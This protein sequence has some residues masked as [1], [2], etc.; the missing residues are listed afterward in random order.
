M[1]ATAKGYADLLSLAERC[2]PIAKPAPAQARP[3]VIEADDDPHRL[4]RINLE[5]Y[6]SLEEGATIRF[7]RDEWYTWKLSRGC[8]RKIGIEELRAKVNQAIKLEFDRLNVEQQED[9]KSKDIPTA[10]KVTK[11]LVTNVVDAMK[12]MAII[13]SSVELMTW[14]DG[15]RRERRNY[16]AMLNGVLD[17]DRLLDDTEAEL[18][19]V[20]LPHS[21]EWFSTVRLPYNFDPEAKCP[22]W[23]A[24]LERNLEMDPERIKRLQEWAGYLLLPDTSL[25]KFLALEGE[26]ANGKSVYI[27]AMTAMVGIENCSSVSVELLTDKFARTQTLGKLVNI[28]PDAGEIDKTKEGD[29][30]SFVSGDV[31]FFDRKNLAGLNCAPTAR[32]MMAF[33]MRPRWG[34]R[35]S[36]IWRRILHVPFTFIVPERE[37]VRGMDSYVWW[38]ESGELP[39][40]LLW[41]IAGLHRLRQQGRFTDSVVGD[42]ATEDWRIEANPVRGFLKECLEPCESSVLQAMTL[43]KFYKL[44]TEANGYRALGERAFGKE[45]KRVFPACERVQ[46]GGRLSRT[47]CYTGVRFVVDEICGVRTNEALMF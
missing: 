17:L 29:F 34:D 44:W 40:I 20:L 12:S 5:R 31:M 23:E 1:L 36:G 6:A 7:W 26:G 21:P 22:R 37:R 14:I 8:Y 28:C 38:N 27:A 18:E 11:S 47:W 35:T 42:E 13:P 46:K 24:F 43:Y 30:K 39:G 4:A 16:V 33:N 3:S 25:Q 15:Q 45:I 41:A 9:G 10:Q 32:M 2:S 19:D